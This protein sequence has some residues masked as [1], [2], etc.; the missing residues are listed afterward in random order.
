MKRAFK[1]ILATLIC[2]TAIQ[3]TTFSAFSEISPS[4]KE[5]TYGLT[6]PSDAKL[7][8]E[9]DTL[10][11][12]KNV[13]LN[14]LGKNRVLEAA[15]TSPSSNVKLY[16]PSVTS[17]ALDLV[18]TDS[19]VL[20]S[21]ID[22]SLL[23]YFPPIKNQESIGSCGAFSSTYY[24]M[25][26]MWALDQNINVKDP[27]NFSN[28]F[29]PKWTF[30][31]QNKGGTDG[32]WFTDVLA[33]LSRHGAP[34]WS[35][36]PYIGDAS[37]PL[38]YL[39][40][41]TD[42]S[43]WEKA[44][45]Y[46]LDSYGIVEL[47]D[48]SNTDTPIINEQ[49]PTLLDTKRMLSN[50]YVLT[51]GTFIE[52]WENS[53]VSNDP[54]TNKDDAFTNQVVSFM[55]SGDKG[56]HGLTIVGYN[57]DI[58][59]DINSNGV[60]DQ[61]EKGAFKVANSWGT[62]YGNDGFVWL[63]YDSINR[64]SAV[65]G[66]PTR[67]WRF[68]SIVSQHLFWLKVKNNYTPKLLA[69]VKLN[70]N[71][72]NEI[73]AY[74]GISGDKNQEPTYAYAS[75]V[76]NTDAGNV[77]FD[78]TTNRSDATFIFDLTTFYD[79][80]ID[81]PTLNYYLNIY[82]NNENGDPTIIKEFSLI[83]K[84]SGKE[85]SYPG[86]L[87]ISIDGTFHN[88]KISNPK[89]KKNN[90]WTLLTG[91]K[92]AF[93]YKNG[94][95]INDMIYTFDASSNGTMAYSTKEDSWSKKA[96]MITNFFNISG[97]VTL[98]GKIYVVGTENTL[99]NY[100][101]FDTVIDAL[102][103]IT[104]TWTHVQK[105]ENTTYFHA[106]G[107]KDQIYLISNKYP[108]TNQVTALDP[109]SHTLVEKARFPY[110]IYFTKPYSYE[111]QIYLLSDDRETHQNN[112]WVYDETANTWTTKGTIPYANSTSTKLVGL[113][114][115]L[116]LFTQNVEY[117]F[118]INQKY[119]PVHEY[120]LQTNTIKEVSLMPFQVNESYLSI[121]A[122]A[123]NMYF[124]ASGDDAQSSIVASFTT[125][126]ESNVALQK[127]VSA[128]SFEN[129]NIANYAVDG[130]ATTRWSSL[131]TDN[132]WYQIDLGSL[133]RINKI[134]LIWEAAYG[135]SYRILTSTDGINFAPQYTI[136][137]E[138]GQTDEIP[139]QN[140][141]D[142]R[143]VKFEGIK[144]GTQWGYSLFEFEVLGQSLSTHTP[145]PTPTSTP[146]GTPTAS[147]T[148]TATATPT[149]PPT[150]TNTGIKT[151]VAKNKTSSASSVESNT[152]AASNA[153]DGNQNTRWSS[154]YSDPQWITVDLGNL[155]SI[156]QVKLNWEAAYGK[157]YKIQVSNNNVN[158]T[159]VYT[160][161]VGNGGIDAI[162]FPKIDAR[163]VRMYGVKR[164]TPWGYSLFDFEVYG[165][166]TTQTPT[167]TPTPTSTATATTTATSTPT[168]TPT[169][170]ATTNT[171]TATS[172][173]TQSPT[174]TP[175]NVVTPTP[176]STSGSVKVQFYNT[177]KSTYTNQL[178]LNFKVLNTG[179]SAFNLNLI[180]I[181]YYLNHDGVNPLAYNTDWCNKL[182]TNQVLSSF[183]TGTNSYLELS[184][185]GNTD[186]GAGSDMML[187]GRIFDQDW[188]QQF[189]QSNDYSFNSTAT[190]FVDTQKVCVYVNGTLVSGIE[191]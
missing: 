59:T 87:P 123:S 126:Q 94:I 117:F 157:E 56:A 51:F 116:Y 128:S 44:I 96:N 190:S 150:P 12:A 144:R 48:Y 80:S 118:D 168:S 78:G 47:L 24:Q 119:S 93:Y 57:D 133:H 185:T 176:T 72:R 179:N 84:V 98:N 34:M 36:F 151:D 104:N 134:R 3:S 67:E 14:S 95:L 15:S 5:T 172:T 171:P 187:S 166:P 173:P 114:N 43:I 175:T 82:D 71:R 33:L 146:T 113:S 142:A 97:T 154:L 159:D 31:L 74:V 66:A 26:H 169:S 1:L 27:N 54:S 103:P 68:P 183:N 18:P 46:R 63:S 35:D 107:L 85:I 158:F 164:A 40:W 137:N 60:V 28:K 99:G 152:H 149:T 180:K 174:S 189:N 52:S 30:N 11:K 124:L 10:T 73:K 109:T 86:T 91:T 4:A 8:E 102:D 83:D 145:T 115:K 188:N 177:D 129:T 76:L 165:V 70:H 79:F 32:L 132:Q 42:A 110:S 186:L 163:Y 49:D 153:F 81:N 156:D 90:G 21:S 25:T 45:R 55:T 162:T 143:F 2:S 140:P 62:S 101:R 20:P 23:P 22:N 100:T 160:E 122:D 167:P 89:S 38:N 139:F 41:P 184:F 120:D 130:N 69:K 111:G 121:V 178:Y 39:S 106:V 136:D 53:L 88:F 182:A 125:Y 6:I 138:N 75:E 191:P 127:N 13:P 181:R 148:A 161:K 17:S 108:N 64:V 9:E 7:Q 19:G 147:A 135:K 92:D 16:N 141:I 50:G 29:S 170:T 58:W 105:I 37:N 77:S 155:Y 61:G 65:S 131:Y 112:L